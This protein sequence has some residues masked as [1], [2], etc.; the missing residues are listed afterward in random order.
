[1]SAPLACVRWLVKLAGL[2]E[3]TSVRLVYQDDVV[4]EQPIESGAIGDPEH[5]RELLE[6]LQ[7]IAR[8][9]AEETGENR[10]V[11]TLQ[12]QC[13]DK[14]E[15]CSRTFV[16]HAKPLES[17]TIVKEVFS[18]NKTLISA[19]G[20]ALQAQSEHW[21]GIARM[22]ADRN[23]ELERSRIEHIRMREE[24]LD[25]THVRELEAQKNERELELKG[26]MLKTAKLLLPALASH[27]TGHRLPGAATPRDVLLTELLG[28]ISPEQTEVLMGTLDVKQRAALFSLLGAPESDAENSDGKKDVPDAA[29]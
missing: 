12:A 1:M 18:Q 4:H 21:Q 19:L 2:S 14:L 16:M 20:G 13:G 17:G 25:R 3:L 28:S 15:T 9:H 27:Y 22:L 10:C 23:T 5:A 26:D 6:E 24:L 7:D 29:E 8:G 11:Y